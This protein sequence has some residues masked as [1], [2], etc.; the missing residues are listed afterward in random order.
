MHIEK[1]KLQI[2]WG[3]G[4][5]CMNQNLPCFNVIISRFI[6]EPAASAFDVICQYMVAYNMNNNKCLYGQRAEGEV[7]ERV[8]VSLIAY[9]V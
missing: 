3:G 7:S 9:G 6:I 2:I 5:T 8:H 1:P 4:S